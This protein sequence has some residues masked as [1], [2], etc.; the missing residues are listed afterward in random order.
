MSSA[1][2]GDEPFTAIWNHAMINIKS[3][4]L[5]HPAFMMSKDP[6]AKVTG[7]DALG[8]YRHDNRARFGVDQA[9]DVGPVQRTA[10]KHIPSEIAVSILSQAELNPVQLLS[11]MDATKKSRSAFQM[12]ICSAAFD[13]TCWTP[14]M[15]DSIRGSSSANRTQAALSFQESYRAMSASHQVLL[16]SLWMNSD[17]DTKQTNT[18]IKDNFDIGLA[19]AWRQRGALN[20]VGLKL[21]GEHA[22]VLAAVCKN[23]LDLRLA[24]DACRRDSAIVWAAIKENGL[25]LAYVLEPLS[26]DSGLV[27][28][29]VQNNGRA[30]KHAKEF[31]KGDRSVVLTAVQENGL[32][33]RESATALRDDEDLVLCAV[34]QNGLALR[35][36]SDRLKGNVAIVSAAVRQNGL[37]LRYAAVALK[38]DRNVVS[39]AVRQEGKALGYA[40]R[41]LQSDPDLCQVAHRWNSLSRQPNL[42]SRFW[43]TDFL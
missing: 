23:G 42:Q 43:V 31:F 28:A 21:R 8:V 29:A 17:Y 36:A 10:T 32:A 6:T 26:C 9:T 2:C 39:I 12:S 30:L 1:K 38:A 27:L 11:L 15:Q 35:Y 33:L 34:Q 25:A 37:A 14:F 20:R 13:R 16:C 41:L 7:T 22:I 19:M 5:S 40:S 4:P 18:D 3:S 24:S